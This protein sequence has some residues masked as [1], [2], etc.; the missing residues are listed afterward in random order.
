LRKNNDTN[1][2]HINP[3]NDT[4]CSRRWIQGNSSIWDKI[5]PKLKN[6]VRFLGYAGI[7]IK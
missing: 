7:V 4:G 2:S 5:N 1:T 3:Y 6:A